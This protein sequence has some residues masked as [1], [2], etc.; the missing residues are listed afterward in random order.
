MN[1]AVL[2]LEASPK[3]ARQRCAVFGLQSGEFVPFGRKLSAL[4]RILRIAVMNIFFGKFS[5]FSD[6]LFFLSDSLVKF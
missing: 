4:K 6:K 2:I 3:T 5:I 1:T